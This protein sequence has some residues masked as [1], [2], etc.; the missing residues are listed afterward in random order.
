MSICVDVVDNK[1]GSPCGGEAGRPISHGNER[2]TNAAVGVIRKL[3][4]RREFADYCHHSLKPRG[5]CTPNRQGDQRHLSNLLSTILSSGLRPLCNIQYTLALGDSG[6]EKRHAFAPSRRYLH[7]MGACLHVGQC[8]S[9]PCHVWTGLWVFP[10]TTL[11]VSHAS[12][13]GIDSTKCRCHN[14]RWRLAKGATMLGGLPAAASAG[15]GVDLRGYFRGRRLPAHDRLAAVLRKGGD[16]V[17]VGRSRPRAL[18]LAIHKQ[19]V[20]V[21][22]RYTRVCMRAHA[23]VSG[24]RGGKL[25]TRHKQVRK[26]LRSCGQA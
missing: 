13:R 19:I 20:P 16:G 22:A 23:P 4:D 11:P 6:N 21:A 2:W 10:S 26:V 24:W 7:C 8:I 25:G 5:L 14:S 3:A 12:C 9:I 17:G 1:L 18:H 15:V